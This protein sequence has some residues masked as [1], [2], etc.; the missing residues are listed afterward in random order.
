MI[1]KS[2]LVYDLLR[3]Q[4]NENGF[5]PHEIL[6]RV[7]ETHGFTPGKG[8]RRQINA[9]LKRG[10]NFGILMKERNRYRYDLN[11]TSVPMPQT[12]LPQG[13]NK[14]EKRKKRVVVKPRAQT[15]RKPQGRARGPVK[16]SKDIRP[17]PTVPP[18]PNWTPKKRILREEYVS[19]FTKHRDN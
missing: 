12:Q 1:K 2:V 13:K 19:K 16:R 10:M 5:S 14:K 7:S 9:A 3:S 11:I 18:P 6:Q 15:N 8:L 4:R 17:N